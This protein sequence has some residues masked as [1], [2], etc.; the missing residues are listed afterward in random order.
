MSVQ[1]THGGAT[2][3]RQ[4]DSSQFPNLADAKNSSVL[5]KYTYQNIIGRLS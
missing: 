3:H 2:N 1:G 4:I 5:S